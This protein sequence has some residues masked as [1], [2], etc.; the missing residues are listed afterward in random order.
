MY[1]IILTFL[2][3]IGAKVSIMEAELRNLITL[4]KEQH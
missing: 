2:L 1:V 4:C 3:A